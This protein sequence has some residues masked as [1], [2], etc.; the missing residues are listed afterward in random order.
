MACERV[1]VP[2]GG[3]SPPR[4]VG[5]ALQQLDA[6]EDVLWQPTDEE[7]QNHHH[8]HAQG[9]LPPGPQPAMLLGSHEDSADQR[10]TQADD[11]EG[12]Q[13]PNG[14]LQPLNLEDVREAEVHLPPV[15]GLDYGEGEKGG[16]DG[17]HPDQAAAELGVLH[18]PQRAAAHGAG[19][20]NVSVEAH[21]REEK[22]AAVH[23][24]LQE[25]GHEGAEDGVV[26]I[27]LIQVEN[28]NKGICHQ[29]EIRH[30]Q[31]NKVEIGDGHLVSVVQV[32]HQDEDVPYKSNR[33]QE[34][35]VQAGQEQT[36]A[37]KLVFFWVFT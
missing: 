24:D 8:N 9:F 18:R 2:Q 37:V 13:K 14:H 19:Q 21:P 12:H 29:D 31:I 1:V 20:R 28:L 26:V 32:Y 16:Q 33:K 4:R 10:V 5:G 30:G 23:V 11:G 35:S 15:L 36:D 25:Q 34:D 6:D 7:H 3:G 27:L 17:G 22:D